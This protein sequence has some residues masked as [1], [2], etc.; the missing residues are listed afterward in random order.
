MSSGG[1]GGVWRCGC[2]EV[3]VCGGG[4]VWR[5]GC[6]AVGARGGAGAKLEL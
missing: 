4:G 3:G 5:C 6:V 2:V 1:G